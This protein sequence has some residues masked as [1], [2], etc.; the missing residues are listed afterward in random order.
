MEGRQQKEVCSFQSVKNASKK[1]IIIV[2][3]NILKMHVY[4]WDKMKTKPEV[5]VK[6]LPKIREWIVVIE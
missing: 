5:K 1:S 4:R 2:M 3:M 6:Y